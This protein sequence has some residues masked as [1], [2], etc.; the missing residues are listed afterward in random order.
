M[1]TGDEQ[2][3][4]TVSTRW[5]E[6]LVRMVYELALLGLT[7]AIM[8]KVMNVPVN[9]FNGWKV[10]HPE[11]W[12]AINKGRFIADAKVAASWYNRAVGYDIPEEH[13]TT[14]RGVTTVTKIMRHIPGDAV[15]AERWL[16]NRQRE[17]WNSSHRVELT[18]TNININKFDFVGLSTEELI[19][20]K[21]L[22]LAKLTGGSN[23]ENN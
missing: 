16:A 13:L 2:D 14:Y 6:D 12:D 1:E 20:A 23:G 19:I 8:A 11:F 22:G 21:K 7:E 9:T 17:L 3:S 5:S 10:R 15:A 18:Q 4:G